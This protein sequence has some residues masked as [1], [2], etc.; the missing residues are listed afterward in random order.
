MVRTP[1]PI[2]HGGRAPLGFGATGDATADTM[3]NILAAAAAREAAEAVAREPGVLGRGGDWFTWFSETLRT[4]TWGEMYA[5]WGVNDTFLSSFNTVSVWISTAWS[6]TVDTTVGIIVPVIVGLLGATVGTY[7]THMGMRYALSRLLLD[8]PGL[9]PRHIDRVM[10]DV[11]DRIAGEL[12]KGDADIPIGVQ[13][14]NS[15]FGPGM[16]SWKIVRRVFRWFA[17]LRG[18]VGPGTWGRS[19]LAWMRHNKI[20]AGFIIMV[21]LG[22]AFGISVYFAIGA[23]LAAAIG[24]ALKF[25][26]KHPSALLGLFGLA[27]AVVGYFDPVAIPGKRP[28]L[29][30]EYEIVTQLPRVHAIV[31]QLPG[32]DAIPVDPFFLEENVLVDNNLPNMTNRILVI[33]RLALFDDDTDVDVTAQNGLLLTT[34]RPFGRYLSGGMLTRPLESERGVTAFT[35]RPLPELMHD[36]RS[37]VLWRIQEMLEQIDEGQQERCYYL[38][39]DQTLWDTGAIPKNRDQPGFWHDIESFQPWGTMYQLWATPV[40]RMTLAGFLDPA[41]VPSNNIGERACAFARRSMAGHIFG[42]QQP[43]W[44]FAGLLPPLPRT[45]LGMEVYPVVGGAGLDRSGWLY[46]LFV[47]RSSEDLTRQGRWERELLRQRQLPETHGTPLFINMTHG[48]FDSRSMRPFVQA[49]HAFARFYGFI[50]DWSHLRTDIDREHFLPANVSARNVF[51][52][53]A[54]PFNII[55]YSDVDDSWQRAVTRR[56]FGRFDDGCLFYPIRTIGQQ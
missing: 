38:A 46:S 9:V 25:I 22:G 27:A 4:A 45:E 7:A 6:W 42:P 20:A 5:Q 21:F 37:R 55:N 39:I 34:T 53:A 3:A 19:I 41:L 11:C 24:V 26:G 54:P 35:I 40:T 28:E 8:T 43:S 13:K 30:L 15:E 48:L 1:I 36:T 14:V 52:D 49:V 47:A 44:P 17:W 12:A 29:F 16:T 32:V 31:T 10:T 33:K 50:V 51:Y 18:L 2:T 56:L 23:K